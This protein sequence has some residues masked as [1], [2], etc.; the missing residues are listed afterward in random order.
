M[1]KKPISHSESQVNIVSGEAS[2][3]FGDAEKIEHAFDNDI[4]TI[5]AP[6]DYA[7]EN[8]AVFNLGFL[9]R[10]TTISVINRLDNVGH[11]KIL[12]NTEVYVEDTT[13]QNKHLCGV[14]HVTDLTSLTE[15]SQTY[16]FSCRAIGNRIRVTDRDVKDIATL[17]FAEIRVYGFNGKFYVGLIVNFNDKICTLRR[18]R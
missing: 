2:G 13:K 4:H 5:F 17:S 16:N 3:E 7:Q 9:F 12:D 6:P 11:L 14:L 8:W 1:N 15:Q 18:L 10:I